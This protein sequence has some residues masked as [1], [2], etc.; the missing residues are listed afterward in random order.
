MQEKMIVKTLGNIYKSKLRYF[1]VL[2]IYL[3]FSNPMYDII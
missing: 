1:V 2:P 3:D